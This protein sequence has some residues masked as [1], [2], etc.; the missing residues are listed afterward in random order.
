V[1]SDGGGVDIVEQ[2][3]AGEPLVRDDRYRE[4]EEDAG[5]WLSSGIQA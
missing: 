5:G 1:C 2:A 4:A 3:K